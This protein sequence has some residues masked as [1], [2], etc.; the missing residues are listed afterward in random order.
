[1]AQHSNLPQIP[2]CSICGCAEVEI[3]YLD[4]FG[5]DDSGR[6]TD[7]FHSAVGAT[8]QLGEC[9]RCSHRWTHLLPFVRREHGTLQVPSRQ[10]L[11]WAA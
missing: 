3:D 7:E 10:A 1:M 5:R 8:L 9:R 6:E 11:P 2:S 4:D